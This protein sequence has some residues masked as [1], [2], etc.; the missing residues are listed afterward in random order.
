MSISSLLLNFHDIMDAEV[1]PLHTNI[2]THEA[3]VLIDLT[4]PL[5]FFLPFLFTHNYMTKNIHIDLNN[6][7]MCMK[8]G[9]PVLLKKNKVDWYP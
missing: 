4:I 3:Q 2:V 1:N 7:T 5:N 9:F 8:G 6:T